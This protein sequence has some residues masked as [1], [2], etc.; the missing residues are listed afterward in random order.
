MIMDLKA[1][2][3]SCSN[4]L[5]SDLSMLEGSE[6]LLSSVLQDNA[7]ECKI[8]N[9]QYSN[10]LKDLTKAVKSGSLASSRRAIRDMARAL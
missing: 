4:Q 9:Q 8:A 3:A 6:E 7:V 5:V 1:M 2:K 10:A